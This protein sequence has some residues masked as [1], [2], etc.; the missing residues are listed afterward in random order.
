ML[1]V[2]SIPDMIHKVASNR[3]TIGYEVL[4]N[5]SRYKKR[6]N[7]KVLRV[8]GYSPFDQEQVVSCNY[9]LYRVYNLTTWEGDSVSNPEA[10]KLVKYIFQ[11][12]ERFVEKNNIIPASRLRKSGWKFKEMEI[13][14][15]PG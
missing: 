14:G 9:P 6:G 3:Y 2:G 10:Q 7:V 13:V 5:V 15:E 4:S 12:T 8:N 11:H 1:E